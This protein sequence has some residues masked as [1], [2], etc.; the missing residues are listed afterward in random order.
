MGE[1]PGPPSAPLGAA[2]DRARQV[3][4]AAAVCFCLSGA[5]GLV[6]EV[7]WIRMMGLVFGHTVYALTTVVAAFMAGLAL[8]SYVLG[9]V[10]D[11]VARPLRLYALLEVGVGV[12]CAAV[13]WLL[14]IAKAVYLSLGQ[15]WGLSYGAF[16]GVQAVLVCGILVIPTTLMGGTLPAMVRFFV[17]TP[18]GVRSGVGR[19]Y[20]LNTFG[21][22]V[23]TA[24]TGLW[25]LPALG[26]RATIWLAVV[27]NLGIGAFAWAMDRRLLSAA[28]DVPMGVPAPA[29]PGAPGPAR[30]LQGPALAAILCTV[31][32]SGAAAMVNQVGWTRALSLIIGSSTYAFTAILLAFL[33]GIAGG[34][35][36]VGRIAPRAQ[37][38]LATLGL[39]QV[40][41]G[42]AGLAMLWAF[43]WLPEA[44]L[45]AFRI[46]SSP[47]FILGTQILLSLAMVLGPALLMGATFPCALHLAAGG[48]E[49]LGRDVGRVYGAN[50]LGAI[51]GTV[52]G[53]FFLIPG[54]GTQR[55]LLVAA[56]ANAAI[57]LALILV[58]GGSVGTAGRWAVAAGV[59]AV[60]GG[61]AVV[62]SWDQRVLTSGPAVYAARYAG[63]PDA[64]AFRVLARQRELLFY[65]DGPGGTVSVHRDLG[66]LALRINGKTDASNAGDMRTQ[67]MSG[68]IPMFFHPAP[69][70]VMV[71]G[72][73]SGV[74]VGAVLQH[75]VEWVELVEI[76]PAVN[77]AAR[78]FAKENRGA[79]DDPRTRIVIADARHRLAT[80]PERYDVIILEP[81]NPWIRGLATLFTREFYAIVRSRLNPGGV[82]LQWIQGYGL[83]PDDFTM[84]LRTFRRKFPHA[85]LWNTVAG[86]Y[87][88]VGA[89]QPLRLDLALATRRLEASPGLRADFA[90]L[91]LAGPAALLADFMLGERDTARVAGSGPENTDDG[92]PLEYS[93]PRSLYSETLVQNLTMVRGA[94]TEGPGS[95][96]GDAGILNDPQ[97]RLQVALALIAKKAPGE[98]LGHLRVALQDRPDFAPARL[99]LGRALLMLAQPGPAVPDLE[100]AARGPERR[101]ALIL[102]GQAYAESGDPTKAETVLRQALALREDA[103]VHIALGRVEAQQGR[104]ADALQNFAAAL[105]IAP[106]HAGALLGMGNALLAQGRSPEA[107]P[108]LREAATLDSL[109]AQ[110]FLA[111]GRA[112]AATR[113]SRDAE[114]A[115]RMA[116]YLD[117]GLV[118]TYLEL[119]A[120]YGAEGTFDRA[121]GILERGLE[122]RPGEPTMTAR[123]AELVARRRGPK[124]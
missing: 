111:L 39:I 75:P 24:L 64:G 4:A 103:E 109:N 19:L 7:V 29:A 107:V 106:H 48:T 68:H 11:R 92:L 113:Q 96:V 46:S 114:D 123:L 117:P 59:V 35:Y 122:L 16:S 45:R 79:L 70:R 37:P 118:P 20:A 17:R 121:I 69:R 99:A 82:V 94:R 1:L 18:E 85:T 63:L 120:L 53:G 124:S 42:G 44:F 73:G 13:P 108:P 32:V 21:A 110:A 5:T 36:L 30:G 41:I 78:F 76:E 66:F 10:A 86:D 52:A 74:T 93:A 89:P 84:V 80:T 95:L 40:G 72:T 88:V 58:P 26:M 15:A 112:Y 54:L 38:G 47:E 98:A 83:A 8:G 12:A 57:A 71:V 77:R 62:P 23:G 2:G 104:H 25:L 6:Y 28:R 14:E 105:R 27:L 87:L 97:V 55:A 81:S 43:D 102:L 116:L 51:I 115:L 67:L 56:L 60:V 50:T 65:E 90:L 101:A 100:A 9:R 31:A 3:A 61:A 33:V 91:N 34:S 119:S 49:R 22:V